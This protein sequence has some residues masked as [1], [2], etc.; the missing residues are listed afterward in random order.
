MILPWIEKA[1]ILSASQICL[2]IIFLIVTHLIITK[3]TIWIPMVTLPTATIINAAIVNLIHL[4]PPSKFKLK[5]I[6]QWLFPRKVKN[7]NER[8]WKSQQCYLNLQ[9]KWLTSLTLNSNFLQFH[10]ISPIK[11]LWSRKFNKLRFPPKNKSS[12]KSNF[13]LISSVWIYLKCVICSPLDAKNNTATPTEDYSF[14]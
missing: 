1:P 11:S 12:F 8:T 2:T 9:S 7:R 6:I 10:L 4:P 3:L 13:L 14:M 5:K